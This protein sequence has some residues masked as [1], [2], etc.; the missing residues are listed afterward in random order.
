MQRVALE[1]FPAV[2]TCSSQSTFSTWHRAPSNYSI[3]RRSVGGSEDVDVT[4]MLHFGSRLGAPALIPAA[5]DLLSGSIQVAIKI[6]VHYVRNDFWPGACSQ[7]LCIRAKG[8]SGLQ[9][10]SGTQCLWLTRQRKYTGLDS[11]LSYSSEQGGW[12]ELPGAALDWWIYTKL[13]LRSKVWSV[14]TSGSKRC[15]EESCAELD[16]YASCHREVKRFHFHWAI[17]NA[18]H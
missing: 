4:V 18:Y 10:M 5:W 7:T 12:T 16:H 14:A 1:S 3:Y 15:R 2:R 11:L 9:E 6:F 13:D 8:G 17:K